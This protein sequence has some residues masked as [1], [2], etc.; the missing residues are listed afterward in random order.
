MKEFDKDLISAL[1]RNNIVRAKELAREKLLADKAQKDSSF[2]KNMLNLLDNS[3]NN[4]KDLPSDIQGLLVMENVENS[5]KKGRYYLSSRE[6]SLTENILRVNSAAEKLFDLGVNYVNSTL[7]F[8]ESGT[9]KTTYGKYLAYKL[10]VPFA[11]MTFSNLINSRL[12]QTQKNINIVFNFIKEQNCVFMIDEIDAIAKKRGSD[13][14]IGEMARVVIGLMQNL[15]E[16]H[17]GV[18]LLGATNRIDVLDEA[19]LRRFSMKHEVL[20]LSEQERIEMAKTFIS[21]VDGYEIPENEIVELAKGEGTQ[22]SLMD[23]IVMRMVQDFS[24]ETNLPKGQLELL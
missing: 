22:A 19:V 15:D 21:D 6:K 3:M 18:V 4:L 9:G 10:G 24:N 7:L 16:L 2:R 17:N 14:E 11:Y 5:F 12:G 20:R 23:S 13:G 8:G 1:C